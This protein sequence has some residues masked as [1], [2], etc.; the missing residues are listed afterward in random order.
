MCTSV[1]KSVTEAFSQH[2]NAQKLSLEAWSQTNKWPVVH[3]AP[4]RIDDELTKSTGHSLDLQCALPS[5]VRSAALD[6]QAKDGSGSDS[7]SSGDHHIV[8]KYGPKLSF[9][10]RGRSLPV[11]NH[12]STMNLLN[13]GEPQGNNGGERGEVRLDI[14]A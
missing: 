5:D 6:L 2:E 11:N 1:K 12:M 4:T 7:D 9:A 10:K 14:E 8:R 3:E 13:A